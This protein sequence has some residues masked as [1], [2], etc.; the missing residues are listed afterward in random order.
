ML[1][2][3][4]RYNGNVSTIL[5]LQRVYIGNS[6]ILWDSKFVFEKFQTR[7]QG[8]QPFLLTLIVK[9]TQAV[10]CFALP[11]FT[12][13]E[14]IGRETPLVAW[15]S[16]QG[17]CFGEEPGSALVIFVFLLVQTTE[18]VVKLRTVG[19]IFYP[20]FKKVFAQCKIFALRFYP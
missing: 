11:P 14:L 16:R 7:D 6:L 18:R 1:K 10:I 19:I 3:L 2:R 15:R 20:A 13:G 9:P 4:Q 5:T 8:W 17:S 12:L